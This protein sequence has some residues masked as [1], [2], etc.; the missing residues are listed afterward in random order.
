MVSIGRNS[1]DTAMAR[2]V[3]LPVAIAT[4]NILNGNIK[5]PGV[6]I[7]ISKEIY[8]PMLAELAENDIM[9]TERKVP[10]KGY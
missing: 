3:G 8:E 10:Y 9:F 1:D 7:P 4:R 5:T 2:T 6:Q